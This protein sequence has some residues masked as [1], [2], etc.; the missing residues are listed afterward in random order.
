[1]HGLFMCFMKLSFSPNICWIQK[2]VVHFNN[3]EMY[4]MLHMTIEKIPV[5]R[6]LTWFTLYLDLAIT[7][8]VWLPW[9]PC[10]KPCDVGNRFRFKFFKRQQYN[11]QYLTLPLSK[12]Y[13]N[14]YV[15]YWSFSLQIYISLSIAEA[16]SYSFTSSI[17][18]STV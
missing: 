12:T 18:S 6:F 2:L 8:S 9:T 11:Q 1:M 5:Q 7:W 14:W 16:F 17:A 13:Q 10:S 15:V 4:L 3:K